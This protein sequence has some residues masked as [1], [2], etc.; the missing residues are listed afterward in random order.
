MITTIKLLGTQHEGVLA[1]LA[2]V[3]SAGGSAFAAFLAYLQGEVLHHFVVEEQALFPLLELHLPTAQGPLAVM[4]AEHA[5]FR[6]LLADFATAVHTGSLE[7]QRRLTEDIIT[8]LRGHIAKEDQVLFPM[9]ERLLSSEELDEVDR[10][11][12]ALGTFGSPADV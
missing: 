5:D 12:A 3:G 7:A 10:R 11:T 8:L 6:Q 2:A 1:Q 4:N 9:A